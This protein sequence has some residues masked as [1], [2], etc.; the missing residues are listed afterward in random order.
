VRQQHGGGLADRG[1]LVG[2]QPQPVEHRARDA[3]R[4]LAQRPALRGHRDHQRALVPGG[5][6]AGDQ[7]VRLQPADQ[8]RRGGGLQVQQV[9]EPGQ[10][11]VAVLPEREHREVLRVGEPEGFQQRPVER[12]QRARGRRDGQADL[13]LQRERVG[14]GRDGIGGRGGI[15]HAGSVACDTS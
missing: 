11:E 9:G 8:R 2:V 13:R 5:A 4:A 7:T 14:R 3:D 12:D 6:G 10:R 1:D 15:G